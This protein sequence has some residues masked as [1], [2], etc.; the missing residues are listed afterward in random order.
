[1]CDIEWPPGSIVVAV[2]QAREIHAA[3]P[4]LKL[5]P[6]ERV[7]VLAPTREENQRERSA[8]PAAA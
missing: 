2:T 6:G 8:T 7:I 5:H 3:R 4:D 1:V